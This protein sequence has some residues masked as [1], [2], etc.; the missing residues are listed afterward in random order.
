MEDSL[1]T[2][3]ERAR[4][5]MGEEQWLVASPR[6]RSAAIYHQLCRLD[7]GCQRIGAASDMLLPPCQAP[8]GFVARRACQAAR[9]RRTGFCLPGE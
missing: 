3:W 9:P 5:Q 1:A 4:A 7:S 6:E 8:D 2:A